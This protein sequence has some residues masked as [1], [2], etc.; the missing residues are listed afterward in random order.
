M[1]LFIASIAAILATSCGSSDGNDVSEDTTAVAAEPDYYTMGPGIYD[2]EGG[3]GIVYATSELHDDGS[4]T[5][6]AGEEVVGQ[7]TW[8]AEGAKVCFDPEGDGE[9]QQER[10]WI[11]SPMSEEGKFVTTRDDGSESYTVSP[12]RWD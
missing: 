3:D 9:D 8:T 10:C 12:R 7:G 1:R 5:D 11:N 6:R 4:Y 2:I